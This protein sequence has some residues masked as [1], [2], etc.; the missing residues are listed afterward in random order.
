MTN[1]KKPTDIPS[2]P[3]SVRVLGTGDKQ[4]VFTWTRSVGGRT[5]L[6]YHFLFTDNTI[7]FSIPVSPVQTD[8]VN[9]QGL[10]FGRT[11]TIQVHAVDA[12]GHKGS[13]SEP[14]RYFFGNAMTT[15]S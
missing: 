3:T 9:I 4:I 8:F 7:G 11:Y 5:P 6:T 1:E 2:T 13:W 14:L 15:S 10:I 12:D